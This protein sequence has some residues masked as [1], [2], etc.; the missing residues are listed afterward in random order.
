MI[1]TE[2]QSMRLK[3]R[4]LREADAPLLARWLSDPTVLA[5]YEGRDRP[6]D[7]A[8]VQAHFYGDRGELVAGIIQHEER[9]IGYLQFYPVEDEERMLYGY[10]QADEVIYGMDQFIGEPDCWNRGIG[11][12]LIRMM[13]RYLTEEMGASRLVMDP[14]VGN[15]RAIRVY[16]KCGFVKV[17]LLP[18]HEWH[19]GEL[20]DCWQM[21]YRGRQ[22]HG[23]DIR[24]ISNTDVSFLWEMLYES[25]YVPEGQ[26]PF[27]RSIIY[28][29]EIAKYVEGWGREGDFGFIVRNEQ[30]R[31]VG[32]IYARYF[33]EQTRGYGY[34]RSDI[35]ELGMALLPAYRGMGLG[36]ALM[37]VMLQEAITRG[38]KRLSLS[39]DPTNTAAMKLYARYGFKQIAQVGTSI[40]MVSG[41][42]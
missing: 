19:E 8:L 34:V 9:D 14:Q 1:I 18:R 41:L 28:E 6:H 26:A 27:E 16:E 4:K 30:G 15:A 10:D 31:S 39:V 29:P 21:E 23:H 32:A 25:L 42:E 33:D 38:I 3:L 22:V 17:K 13:I 37:E 7:L 5:Y 11:R 35:P 36:A 2:D 20:R 12:A 24:P 40:T